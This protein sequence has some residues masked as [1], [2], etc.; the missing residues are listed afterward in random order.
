MPNIRMAVAPFAL[1]LAGCPLAMEDDFVIQG[2]D[3]TPAPSAPPMTPPGPAMPPGSTTPPVDAGGLPVDVRVC[4][5]TNCLLL[6]A[7]CGTASNGCGG[8]LDCGVCK[9][10][11]QQC[12]TKAPNRCD[13]QGPD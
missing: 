8:M 6:G 7:Q 3:D 11:D 10:K 5:P 13:K 1:F 2:A 9:G 4:V 12:G